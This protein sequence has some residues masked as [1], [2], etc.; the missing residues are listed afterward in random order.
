[1]ITMA[2]TPPNATVHSVLVQAGEA[3]FGFVEF[4]WLGIPVS[5]VG[6]LYLISPFCRK[7]L[8]VPR[9]VMLSPAA[10]RT[11]GSRTPE[12][13]GAERSAGRQALSM[14]VLVGVV[15]IMATG[16][17][18]GWRRW[19]ALCWRHRRSALRQGGHQGH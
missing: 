17:T 14:A 6:L 13:R 8:G 16:W 2:G 7:L 1:M 11:A 19:P 12:D 15:I 18:L 10:G 3:G 4:A 5:A 9:Q